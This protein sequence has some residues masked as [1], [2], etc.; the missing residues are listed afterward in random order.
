MHKFILILLS[1]L[2]FGC[3]SKAGNFEEELALSVKAGKEQLTDI[4]K[5]ALLR[6]KHVILTQISDPNTFGL[7][8]EFANLSGEL[9]E[10]LLEET[11]LKWDLRDLNQN[12]KK[13]HEDIFKGKIDMAKE[14]GVDFSN[15]NP[16]RL[17]SNAQVGFAVVEIK[18]LNQKVISWYMFLPEIPVPL[19]IAVVNSKAAGTKEFFQAHTEKLSALKTM[20][21]SKTK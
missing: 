16:L 13:I 12:R 2:I 6:Q 18:S 14:Q 5:K 8:K 10:T 7:I 3:S 19:W 4:E 15:I 20:P 11:Y 17:L 21:L 1:F 9:H